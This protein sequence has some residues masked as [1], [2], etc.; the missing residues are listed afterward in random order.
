MK[1]IML[2]VTGLTAGGAE[3]VVVNLADYFAIKGHAVTLVFMTDKEKIFFLPKNEKIDIVDLDITKNPVSF[4]LGLRK[5]A[6]LIKEKKVDILHR[7]YSYTKILT[8][9]IRKF[10]ST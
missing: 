3:R 1:K 10:I 5:L 4:L 7:Q 6:R 8:C 9:V 2:V